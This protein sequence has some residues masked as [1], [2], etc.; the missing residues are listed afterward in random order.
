MK[1]NDVT[2]IIIGALVEYNAWLNSEECKDD[3][4]EIIMCETKT[5]ISDNSIIATFLNEDMQQD[6]YKIK[7]EDMNCGNSKEQTKLNLQDLTAIKYSLERIMEIKYGKIDIKGNPTFSAY[8]KILQLIER[9][10]EYD[11]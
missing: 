5:N 4:C 8:K 10:E 9:D 3:E 7:I 2:N 1:T 6:T 11:N